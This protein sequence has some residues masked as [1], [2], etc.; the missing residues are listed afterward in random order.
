VTAAVIGLAYSGIASCTP[1]T[2]AG[3]DTSS[4]GVSGSCTDNAGKTASATSP[5]FLYDATAPVL[6]ATAD[7]GDGIA[8]LRWASGDIDPPASVS[9][10]RTPGRHHNAATA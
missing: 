5:P 2:Y 10:V 6:K 7:P 3:L 8:A 4:A 1:T 9:V